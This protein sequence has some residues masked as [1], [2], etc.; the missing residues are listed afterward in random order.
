M[1]FGIT[2]KYQHP[3]YGGSQLLFDRLIIWAFN[4]A[5]YNIHR[6]LFIVGRI[7]FISICWRSM[8]NGSA[9]TYHGVPSDC[10]SKGASN[11]LYIE[12]GQMDSIQ[13]NAPCFEEERERIENNIWLSCCLRMWKTSSERGSKSFRNISSNCLE[14][15]KV[16]FMTIKLT[17]ILLTATT[18]ASFASYIRLQFTL[19]DVRSFAILNRIPSYWIKLLPLTRFP[20]LSYFFLFKTFFIVSIAFHCVLY[21]FIAPYARN[22]GKSRGREPERRKISFNVSCGVV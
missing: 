8:G 14:V 4:T 10:A 20:F 13:M 17:A 7:N 15:G 19:L 11:W 5:P 6:L 1:G 12:P 9:L 21:F 18:S 16:L 2:W 3:L 22:L